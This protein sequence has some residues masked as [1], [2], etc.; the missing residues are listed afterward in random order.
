MEQNIKNHMKLDCWKPFRSRFM[1]IDTTEYLADRCFV[2]NKM[3]VK[4]LRGE[5]HKAGTEYI[6]VLCEISSK[7]EQRFAAVMEQLKTNMLLLD[8]EDYEAVCYDFFN[9]IER[10]LQ[11]A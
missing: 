11:S 9:M 5:F 6:V 1:Y 10:D 4:Y 7:D 2:F 8:H 3:K